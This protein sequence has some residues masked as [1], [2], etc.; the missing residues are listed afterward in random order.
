VVVRISGAIHFGDTE[1]FS[2]AIGSN[3][4][5]KLPPGASHH[6][7]LLVA[8]QVQCLTPAPELAL[9]TIS[10]YRIGFPYLSSC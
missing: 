3:R 6:R 5:N 2:N 9:N 4:L 7:G 10:R 8:I 1:E